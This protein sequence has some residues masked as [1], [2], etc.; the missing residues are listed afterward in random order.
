MSVVLAIE[1]IRPAAKADELVELAVI[2]EVG[3]GIRLAAGRA[4]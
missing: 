1:T 4:E 2:V 3:P